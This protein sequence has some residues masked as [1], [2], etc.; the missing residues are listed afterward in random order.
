MPV[1]L[2]FGA[3]YGIQRVKHLP[4][5]LVKPRAVKSHSQ[6]HRAVGVLPAVFS[7]TLGIVLN[8]SR[9]GIKMSAYCGSKELYN[10]ALDIR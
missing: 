5:F 9:F 7:K 8:I 4:C 6:P 3:K 1:A 2:V 10:P